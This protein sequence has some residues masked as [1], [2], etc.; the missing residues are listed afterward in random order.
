MLLTDFE[1]ICMKLEKTFNGNSQIQN[2]IWISEFSSFF[3]M[4][5]SQYFWI[6]WWSDK[7]LNTKVVDLYVLYKFSFGQI[8][9]AVQISSEKSTWKSSNL[10]L[11]LKPSD[12]QTLELFL[13]KLANN[14]K[15]T[16]DRKLVA[17]K[18]LYNFH[19][20]RFWTDMEE[21]G[22]N[23]NG[24]SQIQNLIW[25]SEFSHFSLMFRSQYF[26]IGW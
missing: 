21:I 20:D 9:S 15:K 2:L 6:F 18:T 16:L 4:F 5:R 8:S 7:T 12:T 14:L 25:I 3:P 23:L 22:E 13:S 17:L 26:W 10:R 11:T 19:V 24:N 1:L